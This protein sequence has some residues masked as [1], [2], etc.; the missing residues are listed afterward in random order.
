MYVALSSR[1]MQLIIQ[2]DVVT[3]ATITPRKKA[4]IHQVTTILVTSNHNHLL[5]T[6]TDDPSL[7]GTRAI[8]KVKDHQHRW[9][10]AGSDLEI[11]HF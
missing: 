7:A 9:L 1:S 3:S 11:E 6:G 5:T 10:A 4:A 8:I 2:L